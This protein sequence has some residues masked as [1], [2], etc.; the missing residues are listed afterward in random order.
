MNV[1]R[2]RNALSEESLEPPV[3]LDS[4]RVAEPSMLKI[5]RHIQRLGEV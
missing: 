5:L 2:L 3:A 4:D 1:V